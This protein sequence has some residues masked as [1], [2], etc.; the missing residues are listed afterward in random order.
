MEGK[1]PFVCGWIS[2]ILCI[3]VGAAPRQWLP[4][5]PERLGHLL[6][7]IRCDHVIHQRA[8]DAA[9]NYQDFLSKH[10]Q[11]HLPVIIRD[12]PLTHRPGA[13]WQDKD[14]FRAWFGKLNIGFDRNQMEGGFKNFS[15][16]LTAQVCWCFFLAPLAS[17]LLCMFHFPSHSVF[18]YSLGMSL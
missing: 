10:G 1:N 12:Y 16:G 17:A 18:F 8:E 3:G 13:P 9:T 15:G 5:D 2:C 14:S 4:H 11:A 6:D 7:T